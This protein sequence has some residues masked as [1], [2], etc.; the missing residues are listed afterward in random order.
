MYLLLIWFRFKFAICFPFM[1]SVPHS[2]F[3]IYLF[4]FCL[5]LDYLS[6]FHFISQCYVTD[7]DSVL[8]LVGLR[9]AAYTCV[10]SHLPSS[11]TSNCLVRTITIYTISPSHCYHRFYTH[12]CYKLH[13]TLI[14]FKQSFPFKAIFNETEKC[15]H[16]LAYLSFLVLLMPLYGCR[17]LS[18]IIFLLSQVLILPVVQVC[19]QWIS[20]AFK[21]LKKYFTF[22]LKR[23]LLGIKF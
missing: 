6:L 21:C 13:K 17:F 2:L 8:S 3:L 14:I 16:R 19:W 7:R 11:N 4:I 10:L 18:G 5:L 9:L 1:S 22:P 20:S 12:E 15:L 23:Y